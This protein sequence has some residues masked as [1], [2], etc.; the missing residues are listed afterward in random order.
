MWD[1]SSGEVIGLP[2][3]GCNSNVEAVAIGRK[4][5]L[6]LSG[7]FDGTVR[8]W[9]VSVQRNV[10]EEHWSSELVE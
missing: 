1:A 5:K 10:A 7:H 8:H 2:L 3:Q 9:H 4:D 6:I